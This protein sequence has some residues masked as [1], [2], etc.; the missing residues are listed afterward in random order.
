MVVFISPTSLRNYFFLLPI[1]ELTQALAAFSLNEVKIRFANGWAKKIFL[2]TPKILRSLFVFI[3]IVSYLIG[4]LRKNVKKSLQLFN[5]SLILELI[6][7]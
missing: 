6:N 1:S 5:I 3:T 2:E 4:F 7:L